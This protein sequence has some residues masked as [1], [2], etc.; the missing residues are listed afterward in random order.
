MRAAPPVSV[1]ALLLTVFSTG[2]GPLV[3]SEI[4][5]E[6]S[7]HMATVLVATWTTDRECVGDVRYGLEG[8]VS[9]TTLREPKPSVTHRRILLNL[10]SNRDVS[11][12]VGCT[13]AEERAS[14]E[15]ATGST[16]TLPAGLADLTVEGT[17]DEGTDLLLMP[18]LGADTAAAIFDLQGRVVWY[19]VEGQGMGVTRVRLSVDGASVL[20][21][22]AAYGENPEG[23]PA[24]V[25]VGFDGEE[26]ARY[27]IRTA[28]H[29]F[30][31]LP[32]GT[33]AAIVNDTR[34]VEGIEYRGNAIEELAKDGTSTV[35][36]SA[37]DDFDPIENPSL[38]DDGNLWTHANAIDYDAD[39]DGYWLGMRNLDMLVKI[40]RSTGE[41]AERVG[42]DNPTLPFAEAS[43]A[44][45]GQHQ[46]Q[47]LEDGL[48]VFDNS[49]DDRVSHP[50]EYGFDAGRTTL[51]QRWA[52][53]SDPEIWNYA[54][55]DVERDA[56]G[57]TRVTYSPAGVVLQ[58][59]ADDS[60]R[61]QMSSP[62]GTGFGYTERI[63]ALR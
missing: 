10:P 9:F 35:V 54:L 18:T 17:P 15:A 8:E 1:I 6:P 11:F 29:D 61:W 59:N 34:T 42:G 49:P 57:G 3:F 26:L 5:A 58:L 22:V 50:V 23:D 2:C 44:F 32:D 14:G 55:G 19:H 52:Y 28:N 37:F 46:F 24:I 43:E 16:S 30:E 13:E 25:R 38:Y 20:Y 31:E 7:P 21:M 4:S 40:D 63:G 36:W 48:L 45:S 33:I 60:V 53:Y 62:L 51:T 12:S 41:V 56:D 27:H 39:S 47:W